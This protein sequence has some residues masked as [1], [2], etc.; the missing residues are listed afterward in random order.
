[1]QNKRL[2]IIQNY[3]KAVKIVNT[4]VIRMGHALAL[5]ALPAFMLQD[6]LNGILEALIEATCIT[7]ETLKWAESRRD[8]V[9]AITS[10]CVTLDTNINIGKIRN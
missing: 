1:M 10:I 3:I 8:A 9:K 5:G 2:K 6:D 7:H 4:E